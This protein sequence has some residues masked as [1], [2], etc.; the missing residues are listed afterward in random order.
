MKKKRRSETE[1]REKE[2]KKN[3][4]NVEKATEKK[5]RQ[6][7]QFHAEEFVCIDYSATTTVGVVSK[8]SWFATHTQRT[9]RAAKQS[10]QASQSISHYIYVYVYT[11][12]ALYQFT[13][14]WRTRKGNIFEGYQIQRENHSSQMLLKLINCNKNIY[15]SSLIKHKTKKMKSKLL[16]SIGTKKKLT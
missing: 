10:K 8:F 16:L 5:R 14:I 13:N 9:S 7:Q 12:A 4:L 15:L 1:E 3:T 11:H 2:R 6:Q